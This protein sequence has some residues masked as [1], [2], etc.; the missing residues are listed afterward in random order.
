MLIFL[1]KVV[2]F[3]LMNVIVY[4]LICPWLFSTPSDYTIAL[5][6]IVFFGTIF[7]DF[8]WGMR[9]VRTYLNKRG[10]N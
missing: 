4:G 10:N 5:G 8:L 7:V 1:L 3:F 6:V 9:M 2:L